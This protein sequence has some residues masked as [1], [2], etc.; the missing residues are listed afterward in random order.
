MTSLHSSIL[1]FPECIA[2]SL[3]VARNAAKVAPVS[4]FG[5]QR[6][7][8][9]HYNYPKTKKIKHIIPEVYHKVLNHLSAL[10]LGSQAEKHEAVKT[11]N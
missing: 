2:L 11:S 1:Q 6:E 3:K 4:V 8:V 5:V 10:V 7:I 9:K